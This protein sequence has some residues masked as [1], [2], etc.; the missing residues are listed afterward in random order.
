MIA[1]TALRL[2]VCGLRT[3]ERPWLAHVGC[4]GRVTS[5]GESADGRYLICAT[6][7]AEFTIASGLCISGPCQ[8]DQLTPIKAVIKDGVIHVPHGA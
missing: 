7:G 6:H 8:G 2:T 5:F 3:R 1:N 4:A